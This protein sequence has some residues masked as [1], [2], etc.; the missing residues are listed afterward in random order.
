MSLSQ[1]RT[2]NSL[3]CD[4]SGVI[5]STKIVMTSDGFDQT[6]DDYQKHICPASEFPDEMRAH[7]DALLEYAQDCQ[8]TALE[9]SD[10]VDE[11]DPNKEQYG[12]NYPGLTLS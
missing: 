6:L 7:Y 11:T 2:A 3:H 9:R 12:D 8:K 1:V 4:E 10:E 5:L